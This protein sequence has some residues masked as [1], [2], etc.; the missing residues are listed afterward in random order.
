VRGTVGDA[1]ASWPQEAKEIWTE[2]VSQIPEGVA[3]NSDRVIVE[4]A[5]RLLIKMRSKNGFTAAV[6]SQ[7]RCALA[8]LGMTPSDRSRV[9]DTVAAL[10]GD[11][12]LE[13]FF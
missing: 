3:G 2:F 11:A 6:A 12:A 5:V 7:L 10:A 8:S 1:P 4:V 9:K 13:E